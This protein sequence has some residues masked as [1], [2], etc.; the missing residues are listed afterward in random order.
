MKRYIICSTQRSGSSMLCA[1]MKQTR[2]LGKPGE[3]VAIRKLKKLAEEKKNDNLSL[4]AMDLLNTL[5]SPN[6]VSGVKLHFHQFQDVLIHLDFFAVFGNV[7]WIYIDRKDVVSQ[8]ISL[9]K[10]WQSRA[11]SSKHAEIK[12]AI[13]DYSLILKAGKL[14]VNEKSSWEWFFA[15]IGIEPLRL[16]Y[17]DI[18]DDENEEITRICQLIDVVPQKTVSVD[19]VSIKKQGGF[20]NLIWKDRFIAENKFNFK[21]ASFCEVN[22]KPLK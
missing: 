9:S 4:V 15:S 22:R 3:T 12:K 20:E 18:L 2:V 17:E 14:V 5:A 11:F 10:A 19:A 6:G 13:Y 1:L 21:R 7:Y 16:F 8:A